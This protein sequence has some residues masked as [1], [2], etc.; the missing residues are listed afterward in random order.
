MC[1]WVSE[2][3][4][5]YHCSPRSRR[6]S[7]TIGYLRF[8]LFLRHTVLSPPRNSFHEHTH[9]KQPT[10]DNVGMKSA[11][12]WWI[13]WRTHWR[14][15]ERE[16]E[17]G[18]ERRQKRQWQTVSKRGKERKDRE[19][20]RKRK[21]KGQE[22]ERCICLIEAYWVLVVITDLLV[23]VNA[24]GRNSTLCKLNIFQYSLCLS[25]E[26]VQSNIVSQRFLSG[27]LLSS[28]E[29]FKPSCCRLWKLL[30][31][32]Y[33]VR[34]TFVCWFGASNMNPAVYWPLVFCVV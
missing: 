25:T 14:T 20:E 6:P 26:R 13:D 28:L 27:L 9:M 4:L 18:R 3:I 22:K 32:K 16:R 21:I 1:I 8:L 11:E 10:T 31:M 2:L 15:R 24:V 17:R 7:E 12:W 29:T 30:D 23:R 5:I 34:T 33:E 19:N